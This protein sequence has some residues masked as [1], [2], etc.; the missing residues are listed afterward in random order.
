VIGEIADHAS[1]TALKQLQALPI[2]PPDRAGGGM[3]KLQ[4]RV[5]VRVRTVTDPIG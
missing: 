1:W 5:R 4:A 3:T 2:I